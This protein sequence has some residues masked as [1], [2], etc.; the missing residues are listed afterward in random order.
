MK[1][2]TNLKVFLMA[3]VIALSACSRDNDPVPDIPPSGGSKLTLEGGPGDG[4][5][6][7]AVY[8]DLSAEKQT[9]VKRTSWD[10]GFYNGDTFRVILNNQTAMSAVETDQTDINAVRSSNTDIND[11]A[12]DW[13]PEKMTLYDDTAG[14]LE[15]TVIQEVSADEN[16][17]NVYLVNRVHGDKVDKANVWKIRVLQ[18]GDN[19]YT[20]QYAKIDD[21][22]FQTAEISKNEAYNFGFFS[23]TEGEAQVEPAK[24]EWDFVW[25]KSASSTEMG[26]QAIP[27]IFG[28]MVFINYLSGVQAQ[29]II[30]EDEGGKSTGNPTYEDFTEQDLSGLALSP[31]RN[32]I[33]SNWRAT[34]DAKAGVFKDRFYIIQDA[35]GNTYKL[36]FL[37]MGAG[38]DGGKRGYPEL[39]YELVKSN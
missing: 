28:D 35:A 34:V 29:Q 33:S 4:D 30:F 7:N 3:G 6:E 14:R 19:G 38:D 25:T 27:Y 31:Q 2:Q 21:N 13:T 18:N 36:R 1:P 24:E 11:L 17:N 5:A 26:P 8:V 23:F 16:Q 20:L 32:V 10:L 12:Y 39:E 22:D 37:A 9:S 15:H